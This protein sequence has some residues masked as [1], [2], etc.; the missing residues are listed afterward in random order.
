MY[1]KN[2]NIDGSPIRGDIL[3]IEMISDETE[4]TEIRAVR[5]EVV[6]SNYS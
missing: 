4:K 6:K 1:H 5:T 2:Q 3:E